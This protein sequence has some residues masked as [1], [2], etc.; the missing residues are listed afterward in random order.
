MSG[1]SVASGWKC[2]AGTITVQFDSFPPLVAGY[3]ITRTDTQKDCGDSNNGFGLLFNFNLLGDGVHTMK[4]FDNGVQF[5]ASTFTVTTLGEPFRTGLSKSVTIT[6]FPAPGQQVTLQWDQAQQNFMIAGKGGGGGG[7]QDL[8]SLIGGWEYVYTISS[9]FHDRYQYTGIEQISG[10]DVLRGVSLA[11]NSPIAAARVQDIVAGSPLPYTFAAVHPTL[12]G[13]DAY[14]F[15]KPGPNTVTGIYVLAVGATCSTIAGSLY[16]M[17]GMRINP[18]VSMAPFP[19]EEGDRYDEALATQSDNEGEM[20]ETI[21]S[22][23]H[24]WQE[25]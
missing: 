13:C 23:L 15:N 4:V 19:Q 8:S 22:F 21:E 6:D 10:K 25:R 9:T 5:G 3:G 7:D 20:K 24:A 18:S 14:F 16:D 11:D 1:L 12:I 2:T 17:V